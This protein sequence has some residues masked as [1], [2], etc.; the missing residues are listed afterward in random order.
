M[1]KKYLKFMKILYKNLSSLVLNY[2]FF[3]D[4]QSFIFCRL[5]NFKYVYEKRLKRERLRDEYIRE[6][7]IKKFTRL[8]NHN[9]LLR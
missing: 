7:S 1:S 6:K 2:L 8:R 4:Y 9:S 3:L 5:F